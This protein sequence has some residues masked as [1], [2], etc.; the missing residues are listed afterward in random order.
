VAAAAPAAMAGDS[1][2]FGGRCR[3]PLLRTCVEAATAMATGFT[4]GGGGGGGG[5]GME[6]VEAV[7]WPRPDGMD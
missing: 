2:C 6:L 3:N 1:G 7:G 4:N 5:L